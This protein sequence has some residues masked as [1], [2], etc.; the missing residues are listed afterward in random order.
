[1]AERINRGEKV[2][3]D[4]V[5]DDPRDP[6]VEDLAEGFQNEFS[7]VDSD[8]ATGKEMAHEEQGREA[9]DNADHWDDVAIEEIFH[10]KGMCR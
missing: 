3:D 9:E 4:N 7:W 10:R 6:D 8:L 1:M 5:R 2:F